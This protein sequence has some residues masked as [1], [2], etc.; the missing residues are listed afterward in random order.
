MLVKISIFTWWSMMGCTSCS[1]SSVLAHDQASHWG[2]SQSPASWCLSLVIFPGVWGHHICCHL[3]AHKHYGLCGED[4]FQHL[5]ISSLVGQLELLELMLGHGHLAPV[6]VVGRGWVD[7]PCRRPES[8]PSP[9]APSSCRRGG[10]EGISPSGSNPA[11]SGSH[12]TGAGNSSCVSMIE[13]GKARVWGSGMVIR[14]CITTVFKAWVERSVPN[15]SMG[16]FFLW[17]WRSTGTGCS[18]SL[19]SLQPWRYSKAVWTRSWE[20]SSVWPCLTS[21]C[22][23]QPLPT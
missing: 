20:L 22:H 12:Q 5:E 3:W 7:W 6:L 9:Q 18:Q 21:R 23:F 8:R 10:D 19:W 4:L 14:S 1:Q 16:T 11:A 15:Q 2:S 13:Q 17:R